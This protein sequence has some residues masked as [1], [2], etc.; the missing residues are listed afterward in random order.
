MGILQ[1]HKQR[2]VRQPTL[3]FPAELRVV[4]RLILRK[5]PVGVVQH[6]IAQLVQLSVVHR[7]LTFAPRQPFIFIALQQPIPLQLGQVYKIRVP[8]HRAE[9][10]VR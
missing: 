4:L 1:R 7:K 8:R 5:A 6:L 9:R 3:I 10:L 2:I